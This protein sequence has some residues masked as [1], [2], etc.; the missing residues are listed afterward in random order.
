MPASESWKWRTWSWR[1]NWTSISP[2]SAVLK[3]DPFR[4]VRLEP[5][6]SVLEPCFATFKESLDFSPSFHSCT[7]F[8][9]LLSVAQKKSMGQL[10]IP[11]PLPSYPPPDCSNHIMELRSPQI[12]QLSQEHLQFEPFLPFLFLLIPSSLPLI[13]FYI[14]LGMKY[15]LKV[16]YG[17]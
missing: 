4:Q 12:S 15:S 10:C 14:N 16:V 11:I 8:C 17:L 6:V 13:P 5:L 9:R 2:S 1:V 3:G 7:T